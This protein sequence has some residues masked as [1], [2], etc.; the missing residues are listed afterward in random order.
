MG[1][2][3]SRD[4]VYA[5]NDQARRK[6][7]DLLA[8]G[9]SYALILRALAADDAE[10]DKCDRATVDSIRI[11]TTKHFPVQQVVRATHREILERRAGRTSTSSRGSPRHYCR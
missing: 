8:T 6:V 10:L 11:H 1:S 3:W 4:A 7:N 2:I 5:R 9:S